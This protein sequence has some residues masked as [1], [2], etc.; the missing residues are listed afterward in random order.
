MLHACIDPWCIDRAS[1]SYFRFLVSDFLIPIFPVSKTT[2]DIL[3]LCILCGVH[4]LVSS[5]LSLRG[6][7]GL[8]SH[9]FVSFHRRYSGHTEHI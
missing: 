2:L 6:N 7:F 4:M 1:F 5:P 9:M 3:H 8:S